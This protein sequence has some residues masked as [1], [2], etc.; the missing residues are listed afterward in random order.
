MIDIHCH[1]LPGLD[2]G[3]AD[4]AEAATLLMALAADGIG[5]VAATPH[6]RDGS[7]GITRAAVKELVAA[8]R[9]TSTAMSGPTV[10]A[11][12]EASI[13]WALSADED[14]LLA[15]TYGGL[16]RHLLVECPDGP[17]PE[18]LEALIA[19]LG[20]LGITVVLAHPERNAGFQEAPQLL[21]ALIARGVVV[22]LDASSLLSDER[23]SGSRRLAHALLREGLAHVV[24][25]NAHSASRR[26]PR[27][28]EAAAAARA[29]AG[30]RADWMVND[31]PAAIL[32]GAELPPAPSGR[33]TAAFARLRRRR[34]EPS[35]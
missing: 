4:E 30:R 32:A 5:V 11:A 9:R 6:Y 10:I 7:P 13:E 18:R 22:Q 26:P 20:E 8:V 28:T 29:L 21:G 25:T 15:A 27:L 1:V 17:A 34:A 19:D 24:A 33:A 3:P 14:A 12:G 35:G 16:G 23:G 2:D 31:A